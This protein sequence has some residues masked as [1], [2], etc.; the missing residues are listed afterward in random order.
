MVRT[1]QAI[2]ES[3]LARLSWQATT[4]L[5]PLLAAL[6]ILL[7]AYLLARV[8]RWGIDRLFRG[9]RL[10]RFL[11][12]T[13][14]LSSLGRAGRLKSGPIVAGLVYWAVLIAGF[15]TAVNVF[16]TNLTTQIV[17]GAVMLLPK[18]ITAGV[19]LLAGFWLAQYLGRSVLV[20]T[21]NEGLPA[22]RRWAGAVRVA[23]IVVATVVA[24]D[25]LD[26]ARIVFL[27]AFLI[28]AGGAV[29]ALSL[30]FG[31]GG[32]DAIRSYSRRKQEQPEEQKE[33][34][35]LWSHL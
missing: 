31:L 29:L 15:L 35:S 14:V 22:P 12:E 27:S 34:R 3:A 30:A 13:G 26:F 25:V 9:A 24:A 10:D 5:P 16:D 20:W 21:C 4:Y 1:L 6:T 28:C 33:E 18:L 23:V 17:E 8:L 19:I 7:F 32:R 11:A 2:M